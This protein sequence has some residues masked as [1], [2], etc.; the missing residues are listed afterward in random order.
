MAKLKTHK[1]TV[2]R[3]KL[4]KTG[5]FK[6]KVAGW[7]HLKS[8]KSAKIKYRKNVDRIL[9]NDSRKGL[10]KLVPGLKSK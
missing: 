1:S 10:A 8:K 2:K 6:Y 9:A 7:G 4:T 5:N 3:F